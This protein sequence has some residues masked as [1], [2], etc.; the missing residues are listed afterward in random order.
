MWHVDVGERAPSLLSAICRLGSAIQLAP[1]TIADSQSPLRIELM[2]RWMAY[3]DDEQAVST[4][5]LRSL[6]VRRY[7]SARERRSGSICIPRTVKIKRIANTVAQNA[8]ACSRS[9]V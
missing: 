1:A 6:G 4:E 8:G 9:R 5:M 2:A 3:F 7:L